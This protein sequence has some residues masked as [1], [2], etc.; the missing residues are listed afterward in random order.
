MRAFRMPWSNDSVPHAVLDILRGCNVTCRACYNNRT[1]SIKPLSRIEV[2]LDQLMS[3]RRLQCVT[4]VGG[5]PTLH[6]DL[7]KVVRMVRDRNLH[8]VI[9][10][11]AVD[12]TT[13]RLTELKSAGVSMIMAHIDSHQKRPDVPVNAQLHHFDELRRTIVARI[14]ECGIGAGLIATGYRSRVDEL[15][16]LAKLVIDSPH[17]DYLLVTNCTQFSRFSEI[18]GNLQTGLNCT[19]RN[20]D[21]EDELADEV[22]GVQETDDVLRHE[23]GLHPMF[24]VGSH[25][26]PNEPRWMSY[27]VGASRQSDD[28]VRYHSLKSSCTE[29][30]AVRLIR[31]IGGRHIFYQRESSTRFRM[32]M[33]ANALTGG[34]L[35][36]TLN[37]LAGTMRKRHHL[38]AKHLLFQA[39][40]TLDESGAINHCYACPD[41]TIRDGQLVPLCISDHIVESPCHVS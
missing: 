16:S 34:R 13:E 1:R 40:P 28:R 7:C 35:I 15:V 2:E 25:L 5:E 29:R 9:M 18:Q 19:K 4:I 11:N 32:Q 37:F 3:L 20:D 14:A 26:E 30:L 23:L 31:L 41:A 27:V 22:L 17:A 12:L 10:S 21:N 38:R 39:G 8:P 33:L 6:P 36:A 24:Y